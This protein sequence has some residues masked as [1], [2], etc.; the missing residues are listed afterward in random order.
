[1]ASLKNAARSPRIMPEVAMK[2]TAA[3]TLIPF[4]AAVVALSS[5]GSSGPKIVLDPESHDF[6]ETARLIMTGQEKDVFN[7]LP[8]AESRKEFIDEFWAKRD[9][10]PDTPENEFKIEFH[11]RIQYANQHFLEGTPGWKTDRGRFYIYLGAP[12]KTD[13]FLFHHEPDV[14][15][16]ILWWIY[17]DYELGIEFADKNGTGQYSFRYHTGDLYGAMESAK[18]GV[19]RQFGGGPKFIN[20]SSKYDRQKREFVISLPVKSLSFKEDGGVLKTDWEF[21]FYLYEKKGTRVD[22]FDQ[23][24]HFEKAEGEL[25]GLKEI[26]FSFPYELKPGSYFLDVKIFEKGGLVK[27]RKIFAVKG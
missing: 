25:A 23:T 16:P 20:F 27:A 3:L 4:L 24:G 6:Y 15:G 9:P 18:L 11:R 14:Q 13:E 17:Y 12:D 8:D 1:M 2:K 7:H 19:L 22:R 21:F 5:C 26:T 10:D